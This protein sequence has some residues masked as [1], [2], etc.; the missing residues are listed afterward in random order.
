MQRDLEPGTV[1]NIGAGARVTILELYRAISEQVGS[2]LEPIFAPARAGDVRDS[3]AA[4]ERA[5][6]LIGYAPTVGWR[7][8][9]VRTVAWYRERS[10]AARV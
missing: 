8:G 6:Q 10:E 9:I 7:E 2:D 1:L 4:I 5:R 3:L